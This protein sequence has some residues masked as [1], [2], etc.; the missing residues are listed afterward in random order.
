MA[1]GQGSTLEQLFHVLLHRIGIQ[2]TPQNCQALK[3]KHAIQTD[4]EILNGGLCILQE[5]QH[6]GYFGPLKPEPLEED[7]KKMDRQDLVNMVKQ[8]KKTED[9]KH[10]QKKEKQLAKRKS[11]LVNTGN[12]PSKKFEISNTAEERCG[13]M[14]SFAL[15]H[16]A[17]TVGQTRYFLDAVIDQG[18]PQQKID[19]EAITR[20]VKRDFENLNNSLKKAITAATKK[21][22]QENPP[23]YSV[24]YKKPSPNKKDTHKSEDFVVGKDLVSP[25]AEGWRNK[26]AV[27]GEPTTSMTKEKPIPQYD[28]LNRVENGLSVDMNNDYSVLSP[29]YP[30]T[31]SEALHTTWRPVPPPPTE[32]TEFNTLPNMSTNASPARYVCI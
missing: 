28:I 25:M 24:V 32:E 26:P 29:F 30:H 3:L 11:T 17:Q 5:I 9:F 7:L 19:M 27:G 1:T 15:M 31:P 4:S 16:A 10:A 20:D 23:I 21:K 8:Y 14:L 6:T 18:E 12:C 22:T 2:L 13:N